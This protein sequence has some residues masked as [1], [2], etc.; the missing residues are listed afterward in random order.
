MENL[1]RSASVIIDI[2]SFLLVSRKK[3]SGVNEVAKQGLP[4]M[5]SK[6]VY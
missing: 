5:Q 2:T 4:R 3:V 1:G 6:P